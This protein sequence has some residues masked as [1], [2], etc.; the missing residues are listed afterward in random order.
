[1]EAE[2]RL[3]TL[4]AVEPLSESAR[5]IAQIA[6]PEP[7]PPPVD[8]TVARP[9]LHVPSRRCPTIGAALRLANSGDEILIA[10]GVYSE[11]LTLNKP[12]VLIA[13]VPRE[14]AAEVKI[15]SLSVTANASEVLADKADAEHGTS[16]M[17]VHVHNI[18]LSGRPGAAT[19]ELL[20]CRLL[21]TGCKVAC[22]P[23]ASEGTCV[24][25]GRGC[26]ANFAGCEFTGGAYGVI[27]LGYASLD[28]CSFTGFTRAA[29]DMREGA[30]GLL[31][32]C[33]LQDGGG[34]GARASQGAELWIAD[35]SF[36]GHA[37]AAVEL[38]RVSRAS[39]VGCT[40][41]QSAGAGVVLTECSS[42]RVAQNA[43]EAIRTA[44]IQVHAHAGEAP[45][46]SAAAA[47]AALA[48]APP[49]PPPLPE[50]AL[51]PTSDLEARMAEGEV[52]E[53]GEEGGDSS[54]DARVTRGPLIERNALRSCTVGILCSGAGVLQPR[55]RSNTLSR[56]E[57]AGLELAR[58][59]EAV[60]EANAVAESA[61][62]GI[63]VTTNAQPLL[64]AN[65]V[66][67]SGQA[68]LEVSEGAV[69]SALRCELSA[70]RGHGALVRG[71]GSRLFLRR[72]KLCGNRLAGVLIFD[73][74]AATVSG[75]D[76]CD[77]HAAGIEV[78][79]GC[80]AV[81]LRNAVR[82]NGLG[83]SAQF[84][85]RHK[86]FSDASAAGI[87]IRAAA[88]PVVERNVL[89]RNA[90]AGVYA[91]HGAG[92]RVAHNEFARNAFDVVKLRPGALTLVE[93]NVELEL[94]LGDEGPSQAATAGA[95]AGG[96][97]AGRTSAAPLAQVAARPLA[98]EAL[99]ASSRA[100]VALRAEPV[101]AIVEAGVRVPF[102]WT[103]K[104]SHPSD[105]TLHSRAAD[106]REKYE[107]LKRDKE[108][109]WLLNLAPER[110]A[111]AGPLAPGTSA[112]KFT[113]GSEAALKRASSSCAWPRAAIVPI[114][115]MSCFLMR[116]AASIGLTPISAYI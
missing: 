86:V 72:S 1:M 56:C 101:G 95:G 2:V 74:A 38:N 23:D 8:Q 66:R 112:A 69:C 70:N 44:A 21:L 50:P 90:G 73:R 110:G 29:V 7:E 17:T 63:L 28:G 42:V 91:D 27:A 16:L 109:A 114:V 92:G 87:T 54:D 75:C 48:G 82:G 67:S 53:E 6:G 111:G 99:A 106:V 32:R 61:Q 80:S 4:A 104:A 55:V 102:D 31:K 40:F 76:L 78:G 89:A 46:R 24:R 49:P 9:R 41:M 33:K 116:A 60:A 37:M 100:R 51:P 84:R 34:A 47:E 68:G 98:Y 20:H 77:G 43:F 45:L 64:L 18:T 5:L 19:V 22:R 57:L 65:C 11:S 58:G 81:L 113:A 35:C 30:R 85:G 93:G 105:T 3:I 15:A 62:V 108:V 59:S 71:A 83:A 103:Y 36:G 96:A 107:T 25:L 88:T 10:P 12:V 94:E 97:R 26:Q 52:G 14:G 79:A 115:S 13:D 39:V